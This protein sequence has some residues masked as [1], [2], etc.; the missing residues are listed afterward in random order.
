MKNVKHPTS[1][2]P[3][4]DMADSVHAGALPVGLPAYAGYVDGRWPS[5]RAICARFG[6]TAHCI[7][8]TTQGRNARIADCEEGDLTPHS[9]ALWIANR[10]PYALG[11]LWT[12]RKEEQLGIQPVWRPGV[13]IRE[14][15]LSSFLAELADAAPALP[16][17][18]YVL[19]IARWTDQKPTALPAGVDAWQWCANV[20]AGYD[21][22][23]I[24]PSFTSPQLTDPGNL[25][26]AA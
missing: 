5:F 8:I 15:R 22:S 23:V 18:A 2:T 7:S 21:L 3:L 20:G 17:S 9:A 12:P 14:D 6:H 4:F 24:A 1:S 16:R 26:A 19:W 13:Y 11:G 25:K 10:V